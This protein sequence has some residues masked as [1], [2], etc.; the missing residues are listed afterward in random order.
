[1]NGICDQEKTSDQNI[2]CCGKCK[3]KETDLVPT[4]GGITSGV[5]GLIVIVSIVYF[6]RLCI[7]RKIEHEMELPGALN[8]FLQ[9]LKLKH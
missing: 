4:V 2:G 5:V 8:L 6:V 7:C 3:H 9:A 1:M